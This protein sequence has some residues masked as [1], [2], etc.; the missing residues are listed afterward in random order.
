MHSETAIVLTA[1]AT[2]G[3]LYCK[4]KE[5]EERR[6]RILALISHLKCTDA[7]GARAHLAMQQSNLLGIAI[8]TC[9]VTHLTRYTIQSLIVD[10]RWISK[11][12]FVRKSMKQPYDFNRTWMTDSEGGT[13]NDYIVNNIKSDRCKCEVVRSTA[14]WKCNALQLYLREFRV[15]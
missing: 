1:V 10:R 3:F 2:T 7:D 11:G 4:P 5:T 13:I 6:Y 8:P 9:F 12:N 15:Q 14:Q